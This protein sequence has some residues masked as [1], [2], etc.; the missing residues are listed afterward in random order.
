VIDFMDEKLRDR[1]VS[2]TRALVDIPTVNLPPHGDEK[3]GQEF[4]KSRIVKLGLEITEFSPEKVPGFKSNPAFI[5]GQDYTGRNNVRG[6]WK[7]SGGGRSVILNGHMDVVTE[8]PGPWTKCEPFHSVVEGDRIYGRGTADMKGGLACAFTAIEMLKDEGFKPR[9]DIYFES[10]VDEEYASSAGS[11]SA[12]LLGYNAD[13]AILFE[14]TGLKIC[15]ACVGS[16]VLKATIQGIAGMPYTGETV[17]NPIYMLGEF[18]SLIKEYEHS[19]LTG[20]KP[21]PLWKDTP[22]AVQ[23]VITKVKSGDVRPHGQLS[24]PADA[25]IELV[26]QT[27]PGEDMARIFA[28]FKEFVFSRFSRPQ[29]LSIELE[30]HY[31]LS[32]GE[33][34]DSRHGIDILQKHAAGYT[35]D[36]KVSGAMFS[37][38]LF[39]FT[40]YGNMPAVVFGPAGEKLHGPDEWVSISSM[41]K[42]TMA[43]RDFIIEWCG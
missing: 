11:I 23:L 34:P 43:V 8:E 2:L 24:T 31:C 36:S 19:R 42:V 15:P 25:W 10:V 12:R 40:K 3:A 1:L 16:I 39:A 6:C 41:E 26:I 17:V 29:S 38:D 13:F 18:I 22:Q 5:Q 33:H 7:G 4:I 21:H 32:S 27:Y 20:V 35:E 30:Y 14:P 37:C 28:E 9:G